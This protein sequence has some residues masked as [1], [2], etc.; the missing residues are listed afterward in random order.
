MRA[1]NPDSGF[2]S[3]LLAAVLA[4]HPPSSN[5]E[6]SVK[7]CARTATHSEEEEEGIGFG[8]LLQ[9]LATQ[10]FVVRHTPRP[11]IVV[12]LG[13]NN[14]EQNTHMEPILASL[15]RPLPALSRP[16]MRRARRRRRR[17]RI[18]K[19]WAGARRR[20]RSGGCEGLRRGCWEAKESQ[21]HVDA[22]S[23][24]WPLEESHVL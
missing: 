6:I 13:V 10:P 8:S 22:A 3:L 2:T 17:H 9:Q 21:R 14:P 15:L 7:K 16:V 4:S 24:Q 5:F 18:A 19:V 11:E 20:S 1:H 23:I 12:I